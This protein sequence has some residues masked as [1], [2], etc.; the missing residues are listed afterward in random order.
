MNLNSIQK[1][2][3]SELKNINLSYLK[4]PMIVLFEKNIIS[5]KEQKKIKSFVRKNEVINDIKNFI[6]S[7]FDKYD[8]DHKTKNYAKNDKTINQRAKKYRLN[9]S[10]RV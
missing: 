6:I 10:K 1:E 4:K 7:Y 5:S 8:I 3:I 9:Q 2:I